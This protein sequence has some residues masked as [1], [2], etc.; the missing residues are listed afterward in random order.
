VPATPISALVSCI[1]PAFCSRQVR[2]RASRRERRAVAPE[3][4][5]TYL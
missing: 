5:G 3:R 2:P 1:P 4:P